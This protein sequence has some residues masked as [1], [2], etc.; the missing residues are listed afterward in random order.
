MVTCVA[1]S[2]TN[3]VEKEKYSKIF[4]S[5]KAEFLMKVADDKSLLLIV[6]IN[7]FVAR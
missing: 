1:C 4:N 2:I 3:C 7:C 5:V 6:T